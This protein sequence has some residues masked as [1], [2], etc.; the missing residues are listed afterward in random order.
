M[1]LNNRNGM[2]YWGCSEPKCPHCDR[3]IEISRYEW[4]GVYDEGEHEVEC[5]FCEKGF[6]VCTRLSRTFSTDEQLEEYAV[7]AGAEHGKG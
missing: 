3:E 7:S 1:P 6:Q 4:W 2:E 5:P